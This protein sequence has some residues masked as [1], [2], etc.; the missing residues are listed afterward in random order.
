M[1]GQEDKVV[2]VEQAH[3]DHR[4]AAKPKNLLIL[5]GRTRLSR[6]KDQAR[7]MVRICLGRS[8]VS[9]PEEAAALFR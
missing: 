7:A 5:L 6:Q 9:L 8:V 1:H 2:L 4:L 3:L